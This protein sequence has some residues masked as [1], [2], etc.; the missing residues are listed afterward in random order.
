MVNNVPYGDDAYYGSTIEYGSDNGG[1]REQFRINV[2]RQKCQAI[3]IT[4]REYAVTANEDN[5]YVEEGTP[6]SQV[7]GPG[8]TIEAI[9]ALVGGKGTYPRL[10][11]SSIVSTGSNA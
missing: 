2:S 7:P 6:T 9:G 3:Q 5:R 1:P 10:S 11:P 8:L 4:I